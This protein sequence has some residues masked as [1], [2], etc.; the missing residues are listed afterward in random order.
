M[1]KKEKTRPNMG[2]GYA[3]QGAR[4]IEEY[5]KKKEQRMKGIMD[6]IMSSRK[7]KKD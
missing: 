7:K 2:S 5:S 1:A 6:E 3:E 4:I